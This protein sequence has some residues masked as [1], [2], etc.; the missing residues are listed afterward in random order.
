MVLGRWA[1]SY[2]R[3]TPVSGESREMKD[4]EWVELSS[5]ITDTRCTE[6]RDSAQSGE[7]WQ[8]VRRQSCL[9]DSTARVETKVGAVPRVKIENRWC[10]KSGGSAESHEKW[11]TVLKG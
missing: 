6:S 8:M 5:R 1:V 7:R 2:E 9:L 4:G 3:G 10:Q 11:Q